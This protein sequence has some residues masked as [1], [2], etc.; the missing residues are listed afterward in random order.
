MPSGPIFWGTLL[1]SLDFDRNFRFGFSFT[2]PLMAALLRM[3]ADFH[4]FTDLAGL[5]EDLLPGAPLHRKNAPLGKEFL[6]QGRVLF[7][8]TAYR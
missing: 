5:A 4:L 6:L 1:L 7:F 2:L 8:K 3:Y